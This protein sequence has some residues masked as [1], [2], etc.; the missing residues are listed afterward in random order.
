MSDQDVV[1]LRATIVRAAEQS[2]LARGVVLRVLE[3]GRH[4][5]EARTEVDA[6]VAVAGSHATGFMWNEALAVYC[7]LTKGGRDVAF[8]S[9]GW[10]DPG[11]RL[12][13]ML[14][15]EPPHVAR[16]HGRYDWLQ[17]FLLTKR[18]HLQRQAHVRR[19][20]SRAGVPAVLGRVQ[21]QNTL[22]GARDVDRVQRR[23]GSP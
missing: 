14:L 1:N 5:F 16:F 9:K 18:H 7:D 17:R 22:A 13:Q 10:D 19:P 2:G 15:I 4:H 23:G 8:L 11:Y 12:G 20:R 21:W 6:A 3:Q